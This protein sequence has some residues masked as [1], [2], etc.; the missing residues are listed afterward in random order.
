MIS[1]GNCDV[2]THIYLATIYVRF[3]LGPMQQHA[4]AMAD[5]KAHN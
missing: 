1:R 2:A 3:D 4:C 5:G